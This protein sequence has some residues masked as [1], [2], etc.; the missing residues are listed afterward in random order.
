MNLQDR[1]LVEETQPKVYIGRR[2]YPDRNGNKKVSENWYAEA[3]SGGKRRYSALRTQSKSVAIHR[4]H[5]F[6]EQLR[7]HPHGTAATGRQNASLTEVV[8]HYLEMQVNRGRAPD[9]R[10]V[11]VR[12]RNLRRMGGAKCAGGGGVVY[13]AAFLAVA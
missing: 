12:P 8:R 4:A 1:Q 3:Y 2:I 5:Q 9:P 7:A 13:R 6:A 11:R 10:E